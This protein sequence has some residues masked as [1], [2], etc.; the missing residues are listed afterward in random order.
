[1][2]INPDRGVRT[3]GLYERDAIVGGLI[4]DAKLKSHPATPGQLLKLEDIVVLL[5][6]MYLVT[7]SIRQTFSTTVGVIHRLNKTGKEFLFDGMTGERL[8]MRKMFY[9]VPD[10]DM[11]TAPNY[12]YIRQT[13]QYTRPTIHSMVARDMVA[14]YTKTV[15]YRGGN[16]VSYR[17]VCTPSFN[18]VSID[19]II[20][21]H[22]PV[23]KVKLRCK[24]RTYDSTMTHTH[25]RPRYW[26]LA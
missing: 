5:K 6:P 21:F 24:K 22:V 8:N 19:R 10:T 2:V 25:T 26:I 12:Q 17:K 16:N 20:E 23:Y 15:S 11:F 1:M 4:R 9:N 13:S 14:K 3:Y 7:A 18:S